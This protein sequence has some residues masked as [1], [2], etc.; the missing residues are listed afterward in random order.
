MANK[1]RAALRDLRGIGPAMVKDFEILG[2]RTVAELAKQNGTTLYERLNDI[3]GTRQDPCVLDTFRC[4]VAQ[5]RNPRLPD[6]QRDW[7]YWSRLRK[8][9]S[10]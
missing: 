1:T 3:T 4:A 6:E 10:K 7:W 5:A 8:A 9:K 2:I